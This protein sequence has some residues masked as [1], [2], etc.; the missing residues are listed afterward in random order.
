MTFRLARVLFQTLKKSAEILSD[1]ST[2]AE[3]KRVRVTKYPD[4][5]EAL[6]TWVL[7]NEE[8]IPISGDIL[9]EKASQFMAILHPDAT[10][11]KLYNGW[12]DSFKNRHGIKSW[13]RFGESGSVDPTIISNALPDLH[14]AT[15]NYSLDD[16]YNMD[17]TGL[18]FR[19]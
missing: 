2:H 15:R 10:D 6:Y 12:L 1:C 14:E 3:T 18:F 13:R 11:L 9:R 19:M 5:D 4:D 7:R 8:N 17:E 16:I